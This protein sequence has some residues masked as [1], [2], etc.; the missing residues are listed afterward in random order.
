MR[1]SRL[2][3][4]PHLVGRGCLHFLQTAC[5]C[6]LLRQ[7]SLCRVKGLRQ[8]GMQ[9][10]VGA[11]LCNAQ[12]TLQLIHLRV[13]GLWALCQSSLQRVVLCLSCHL[14]DMRGNRVSPTLPYNHHGSSITCRSCRVSS[15]VC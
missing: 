2:T 6:L 9:R 4:P 15:V 10:W 13:G 7:Q 5:K 3:P 14:R 8:V 11:A 12:A 1:I